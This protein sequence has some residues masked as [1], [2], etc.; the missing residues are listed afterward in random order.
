MEFKVSFYLNLFIEKESRGN[1]G[2]S[3]QAMTTPLFF[4]PS[5]LA[6]PSTTS[7]SG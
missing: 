6:E 4:P 1:K 7:R 2:E 3:L 5:D